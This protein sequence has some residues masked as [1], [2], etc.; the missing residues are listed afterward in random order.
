MT[1]L[2]DPA[3]PQRARRR[4]YAAAWAASVWA[5][6][7][8]LAM[9]LVALLAVV[10]T[11]SSFSADEGA[12]IVQA[13]SLARGAGW[14]VAHPVPE[15]DPSGVNYPLE[16]SERGVKGW[17]PYAKHPLYPLL[18]A[19]ADRL[20]GG[21]AAMVALSLA[22]T[23]AAAG[24]AAALAR[25]LDPALGRVALW[26]V[27]L[28]SPLLFDGYLLIAHT[29]GAALAAGAVLAAAVAMERRSPARALLVVPPVA[30]C[31][32]LRSEGVFLAA[33]L[34]AVAGA[35]ALAAVVTRR[36]AGQWAPAATVALGSLAAGA[37]AFVM[38]RRWTA[39][40]IGAVEAAPAT[41]G[42]PTGTPGLVA[43]RVQGFV[44]TWLTPSYGGAP[45]LGLLLLAMLAA[46][47]V[48]ALAVRRHPAHGTRVV[49]ATGVAAA[50][51]VAAFAVAPANVVPGLLLAFPVASAGLFVAGRRTLRAG[52]ARL[53]AGVAVLFALAV[54]ATQYAKGG[55]GEWGGRYFALVIPIAVPVLLLAL[56]DAGAALAPAVARRAAAALV[57]CSVALMSMGVMA[58]RSSH[59]ANLRLVTAVDRAG[60]AASL[61]RPV[62]VTTEGA[63]PRFAWPTFDRQRWLLAGPDGL[64][65]LFPRLGAAGVARVG[66][67]TRNLDRDRALLAAA[68]VRVVAEDASEGGRRWHVM[69]LELG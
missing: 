46:L 69:V 4:W 15:A 14:L 39:H 63:M 55:G 9:V 31:V 28:A 32:L 43:G 2:A 44:V 42:S 38:E 58:L 5:H 26:T 7:A 6:L 1:L 16:F 45:L 67:V 48:A 34:G 51:A 3:A 53:A 66:F 61:D 18:L 12:A 54:A 60:R 33:A 17:A 24:L 23:L 13:R 64:G 27:G 68:G 47:A 35:A 50:A 59:Q 19:G 37:G 21:I 56:K 40:L 11:S 25:R 22:G 29:L 8:A 62:M 65:D 41:T 10:G 52:A 49:A 57:V 30:L 36:P 20:G